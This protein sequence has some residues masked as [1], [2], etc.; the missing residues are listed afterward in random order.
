MRASG[1]CF[2]TVPA[3]VVPMRRLITSDRVDADM[4]FLK[5]SVSQMSS[6]DFQKKKR[7]ETSCSRLERV[8]KSL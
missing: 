4:F 6:T 5:S 1:T 8:M 7:S 2:R 3:T